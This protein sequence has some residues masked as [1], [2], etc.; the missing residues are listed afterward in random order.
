MPSPSL[1][2]VSKPRKPGLLGGQLEHAVG[3]LV[4][5]VAGLLVAAGGEDHG[6]VRRLGVVP[7]A[8]GCVIAPLWPRRDRSGSVSPS[9]AVELPPIS[10][11]YYPDRRTGF[12]EPIGEVAMR[13]F[14]AGA[15]GVVGRRAVPALV[16]AGHEV[17]AVVRSPAKAELARSLGATP[18]EVEPLRPRRAA[19]RGRGPRRGVQPR[20]AHPAVGTRRRAARVGREHAHPHRGVAQSRRRR[21]RRGRA[22]VRAGV[23]RVPLRRPRRRV[24]RRVERTPIVETPFTEPVRAAESR[25]RALR[26][27]RRAG[28][29]AALRRLPRARQRPDAARC[30]GRPRRG[31]AIDPGAADGW[32]PVDPRRRRG[33]APSSPR[34]TRRLAPTTSSTTSRCAGATQRAGAR[35]GGRAPTAVLDAGAPKRVVGPLVDSQRVSNRRFRDATA[36]AAPSARACGRRGRATVRAAGVEPALSG[37]VRL[38][39]WLLAF[40]NLG[41]GHPGRVHAPFVLRRLPARSGLGGDGRALQPAPRA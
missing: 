36:W 29:G 6:V 31:L 13:V 4:V 26:R 23:D 37:R 34:S 20:D 5:P 7:A 41:V 10:D 30:C 2:A 22:G 25:G 21:A 27:R 33:D 9:S 3:G 38:L 16:A 40:G 35:G 28:C 8:A 32:F 17:T 12:R 19:R 39:L 18:V 14:V 24:G 15:T 1:R 11:S